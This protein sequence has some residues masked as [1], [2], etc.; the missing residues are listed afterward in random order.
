MNLVKDY[1]LARQALQKTLGLFHQSAHSREFAIEVF[2]AWK[3][4]TKEGL[5]HTPNAREPDH[6][7]VLPGRFDTFDPKTTCYHTQP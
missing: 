7:S 5:A 1:P 3:R 4:T 6:R 2:D